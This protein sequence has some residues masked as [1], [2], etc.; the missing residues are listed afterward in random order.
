MK[1][2]LGNQLFQWAFA[3]SVAH[4]L[5]TNYF[6]DWAPF[7]EHF[8][9][10]KYSLEHFNIKVPLAKNTDMFGFVWLG[11]RYK[12]FDFFYRIIRLK[13]LLMPFY[14]PEQTFAF[15]PKVFGKKGTVY[16]DGFWQTEKYFKNIESII[17]SEVTL[18]K[19]LSPYSK[20]IESE[21]NKSQTPISLHV[22]RAD[23][24]N[25]PVMTA[26]HGY[27]SPE[28]YAKAIDRVV[29]GVS[30]PHFF[31]FSDDYDWVVEHFKSLPYPYTC[32]KNSADKNYEDLYLMSRC[33]RHIISNSSFGWWGA[34]L[35]PRKDKMVI[36]PSKWFNA[37]KNDTKDLLPEGWV[38]I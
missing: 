26:F 18:N 31:I 5:K 36:A 20:S 21:I 22:R 8:K 2:G 25:N 4:H 3:R 34:W 35:N 12:F 38:K 17:R 32:I 23:L 24:V 30:N 27:C 15:D 10:H 19:P 28:F 1:G 6:I 9:V 29:E 14:Y 33:H 37:G 16:F 13:R 11:R 7:S